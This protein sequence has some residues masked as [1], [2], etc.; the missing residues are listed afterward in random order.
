MVMGNEY[1]RKYQRRRYEERMYSAKE[2]FGGQCKECGST[3]N[4]QFDHI[5]PELK[6]MSVSLMTRLTQAKFDAELEKCQL[7]CFDCHMK[8]TVEN[9]DC[10][11]GKLLK[12]LKRKGC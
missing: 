12:R 7:L 1:H 4:L 3:E 2:K 6:F 5:D 11:K 8:K 10:K 9:E